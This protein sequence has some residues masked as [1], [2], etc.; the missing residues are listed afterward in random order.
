V[1]LTRLKIGLL[2]ASICAVAL[3]T[4]AGSAAA[5]AGPRCTLG[6]SAGNT[7]TCFSINGPGLFVQEMHASAEILMSGRTL[8]E[9]IHGPDSA[10]PKCTSFRAIPPGGVQPITWSPN[11]TVSAGDYCAR[12]WRLNSDGSHT[13]IG[14]ACLNVHA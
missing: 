14:E 11:R 12:T 5:S 4:S 9:C 8:Q 6:S 1:R 2:A 10:L 13:L 3:F 7:K